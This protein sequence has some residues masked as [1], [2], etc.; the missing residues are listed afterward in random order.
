MSKVFESIQQGIEKMIG[1]KERVDFR[2][3]VKDFATRNGVNLNLAEKQIFKKYLDGYSLLYRRDGFVDSGNKFWSDLKGGFDE[4]VYPDLQ[5]RIKQAA[6]F[7]SGHLRNIPPQL[8]LPRELT[9]I[10]RY[11]SQKYNGQKPENLVCQEVAAEMKALQYVL[12]RFSV[13]LNGHLHN[14]ASLAD[15]LATN[16]AA[17]AD[18]GLIFK[19]NELIKKHEKHF[20][21][22]LAFEK[23]KENLKNIGK[24]AITQM[25]WQ[26]PIDW[27]TSAVKNSWKMMQRRELAPFGSFVKDAL[28]SLGK[29]AKLFGKTFSSS[30]KLLLVYFQTLKK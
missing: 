3:R 9:Q 11:F 15:F 17:A 12:N 2:N 14:S 4:T 20:S 19:L 29:S 23:E 22:K 10:E 27:L 6:D 21:N 16:Q 25:F 30:I 1:R 24:E 26:M 8:I 13:D 18:L 28:S 5:E 7:G